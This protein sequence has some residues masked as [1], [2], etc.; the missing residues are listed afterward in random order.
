MVTSRDWTSSAYAKESKA[1]KLVEQIL[2]SGLWKQC[3]HIVKLT[4][5]LVRMLRIADSK[6]KPAMVFFTKLYIKPER[7]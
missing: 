6:D 7:R 1:K 5:P 3:V 4:E 2:D